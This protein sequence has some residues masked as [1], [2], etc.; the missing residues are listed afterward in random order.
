M[1]VDQGEG[2]GSR[3]AQEGCSYCWSMLLWH[4]DFNFFFLIFF[5]ISYLFI[6][7]CKVLGN[8]QFEILLFLALAKNQ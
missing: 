4:R 8:F 6:P 5:K 3:T 7:L 1:P 2:T